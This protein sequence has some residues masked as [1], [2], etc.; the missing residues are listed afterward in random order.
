MQLHTQHANM[1]AKNNVNSLKMNSEINS[2]MLTNADLFNINI[3][4][5]EITFST[6]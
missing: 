2:M 1:T 5:P 4:M 6:L 3:P